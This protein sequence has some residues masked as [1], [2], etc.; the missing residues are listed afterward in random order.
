[1]TA[2]EGGH[3]L[4][5]GGYLGPTLA[6]RRSGFRRWCV[7]CHRYPYPGAPPARQVTH[8]V[9]LSYKNNSGTVPACRV[10]LDG[11][12]AVSRRAGGRAG[13]RGWLARCCVGLL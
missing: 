10:W 2:P 3:L 1:V 5:R 7:I 11:A 9:F 4:N 13:G 6:L 12:C 8:L